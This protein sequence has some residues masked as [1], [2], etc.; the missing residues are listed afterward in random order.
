M[1][2]PSARFETVSMDV[3]EISPKSKSGMKKVLV[4]GDVFTRFMLA[5]ALRG[6]SMEEVVEVLFDR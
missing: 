1:W 5:I 6:E 3:L 4:I 2:N